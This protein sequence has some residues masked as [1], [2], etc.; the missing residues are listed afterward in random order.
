[1]TS[2]QWQMLAYGAIL[3]LLVFFLPRGI[4]PALTELRKRP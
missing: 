3:V 1:V 2:W 4:V